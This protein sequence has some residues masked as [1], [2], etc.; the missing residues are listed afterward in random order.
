MKI[1]INETHKNL[2]SIEISE[3]IITK[4]QVQKVEETINNLKDEFSDVRLII[5][6]GEHSKISFK[7]VL[8]TLKIVRDDHKVIHKIAI[9]GNSLFIKEGTAL[10]NISLPWTE[11][12]FNIEDLEKAWEWI[13]H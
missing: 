12:Y 8:E 2:I 7:A 1:E 3:E 13:T 11:K 9:V 10:D 5:L 4:A 6:I